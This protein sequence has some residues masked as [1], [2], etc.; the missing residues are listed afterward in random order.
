MQ[1]I[2]IEHPTPKQLLKL[3]RGERV[4]IRQGTG[5]NIT[6][7]PE[8]YNLVARAFNK[9]KA[10]EV[11]LSPEELE[12]M[13]ISTGLQQLQQFDVMGNPIETTTPAVATNVRAG[14]TAMAPQRA[15]VAPVNPPIHGM[16]LSG[17]RHPHKVNDMASQVEQVKHYGEMNKHLGTNFDYMGS[18]GYLKAVSDKLGASLSEAGFKAKYPDKSQEEQ[19]HQLLG[20]GFN[21]RLDRTVMGRGV[22]LLHS[23]IVPPAYESQPH[24]ANFQ[25]NHFLPPQFQSEPAIHGGSLVGHT[26]NLMR[27]SDYV[28]KDPHLYDEGFPHSVVMPAFYMSKADDVDFVRQSMKNPETKPEAKHRGRKKHPKTGQGLYAS[29]RAGKGLYAGGTSGGGLGP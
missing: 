19:G 26:H 27:K 15:P 13:N 24:G 11:G 20:S 29:G 22:S 28:K 7:H 10:I 4:R 16:G 5:F 17:I 18:A 25:F 2:D 3:R 6:V 8:T 12:A 23:Q 21:H 14:P 1:S 9:S